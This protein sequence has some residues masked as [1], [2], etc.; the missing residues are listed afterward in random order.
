MKPQTGAGP[1]GGVFIYVVVVLL[2]RVLLYG[3]SKTANS[4]TVCGEI[5]QTI[6]VKSTP[7]LFRIKSPVF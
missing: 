3:P 5:L 1:C 6:L 7:D 2:V 4:L